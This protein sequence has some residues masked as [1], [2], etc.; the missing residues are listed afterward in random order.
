[1]ISREASPPSGVIKSP[2]YGPKLVRTMFT[3]TASGVWL[4]MPSAQARIIVGVAFAGGGFWALIFRIFAS[5]CVD[6][7]VLLN[8][9]AIAPAWRRRVVRRGRPSQMGNKSGR[10]ETIIPIVR[11]YIGPAGACSIRSARHD[12][13]RRGRTCVELHTREQGLRHPDRDIVAARHVDGETRRRSAYSAH[14]TAPCF[15]RTGPAVSR[16]LR[17]HRAGR[18][19]GAG[20]AQ[21]GGQTPDRT[22]ALVDAGRIRPHADRPDHRRVRPALSRDRHRRGFVVAPRQFHR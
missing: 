20:A 10:M 3:F 4:V 8:C 6:I 14:D 17:T 21:R 22:A 11:I 5:C 1:M 2:W 19:R 12:L 7:V 13:L 18:R 16:T 15:D 9:A